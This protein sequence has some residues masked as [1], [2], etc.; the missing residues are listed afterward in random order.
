MDPCFSQQSE[1]VSFDNFLLQHVKD[2]GAKISSD[3]VSD[4]IFAFKYEGS[5]ESDF[6][7][8]GQGKRLMLTWRWV[9]S[10]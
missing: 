9:H 3:I 4:M 1:N 7:K 6:G 10:D 2:M 5:S 8:R